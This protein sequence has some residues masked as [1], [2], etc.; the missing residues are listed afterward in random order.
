MPFPKN[1]APLANLADLMGEARLDL[2]KAFDML[3]KSSLSF[4][5]PAVH[6]VALK[7]IAQETGLSLSE[8]CE[9]LL[10]GAVNDTLAAKTLPAFQ[11]QGPIRLTSVEPNQDKDAV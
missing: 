9:R 7:V 11:D 5:V 6:A 2:S 1:Q 10:C 8:V 4:R 3:P